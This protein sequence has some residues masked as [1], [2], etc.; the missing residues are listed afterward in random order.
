MI[1][2]DTAKQNVVSLEDYAQTTRGT[3]NSACAQVL[4]AVRKL[5]EKKLARNVSTMMGKVDDALFARAEMAE[6]SSLQTQYHQAMQT[7]R[8]SRKD[9]EER[10][11]KRFKHQFNE[12]IPRQTQLG[13][14]FGLECS[15]AGSGDE[16]RAIA[17]MVHKT[18]EAICAAFHGAAGNIETGSEIRLL[19]LKL[20]DE[21]VASNMDELYR[22]LD[23]QLV[24]MGVMP[25]I[26]GALSREAGPE[27]GADS[28]ETLLSAPQK[29]IAPSPAPKGQQTGADRKIPPQSNDMSIDMVAMIF[30]YILNDRNIAVPMRAL[31]GRLQIPLVKVAML[32]REFFSSKAH[33]A[34]QLL[35]GLAATAMGWDEQL[36]HEDPSY[37]KVEAIVQT[38]VDEFESDI[39]LFSRLLDDLETFHNT[40]HQQ[41]SV[42][43]TRDGGLVGVRQAVP[44]A[45]WRPRTLR[46]IERHSGAKNDLYTA[47]VSQLSKGTWVEFLTGDGNTTRAKLSW[48]SPIHHTYLFT[49]PQGVKVGHYR[50]EE[51]AELMRCA[52]ANIIGA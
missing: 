34:R 6:S 50:L 41:T 24:K 51:L 21:H 11:I 1:M 40:E 15:G 4:D 39:S 25:D 47:R 36:G 16:N 45:C 52:R 22:E 35:N 12:G 3:G 49:D 26:K 8:D 7:L 42:A 27:A 37:R 28:V 38:I 33:P 9:V 13:D 46:R 10:F 17:S 20:F 44:R 48:I 23:Q 31:L 29:T 18:R 2:S 5:V 30:D 14:S 19:V 32:E 43:S